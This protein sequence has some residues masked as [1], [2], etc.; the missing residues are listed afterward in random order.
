MVSY[1][2]RSA[3]KI[4]KASKTEK[5]PLT[6]SFKIARGHNQKKVNF[7][8][9]SSSSNDSPNEHEVFLSF[10]GSYGDAFVEHEK[11]FKDNIE[12]VQRWR[13]ALTEAANHSGWECSL[14][15]ME[16]E[17]VEK[18]ALDVLEKLNRVHV[19]DLD[20]QITKYQQLAQLQ[21]KSFNLIGY[22]QTIDHIKKLEVER[23]FRLLRL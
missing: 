10:R 4:F 6:L 13:K 16:S 7:D 1:S 23:D 18:I 2:T 21:L 3:Y 5:E 20:R 11:R 9:A 15:S 12:K 8:M 14:N 19:G 22:N 17:I